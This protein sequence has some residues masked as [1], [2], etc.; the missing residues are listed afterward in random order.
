MRSP[1]IAGFFWFWDKIAESNA[2]SY[3]GFDPG[4]GRVTMKALEKS[5]AHAGS[6]D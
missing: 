6:A 3:Y 1:A 2:T 5:E 4:S